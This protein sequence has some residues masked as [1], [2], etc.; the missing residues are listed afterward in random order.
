MLKSPFLSSHQFIKVFFVGILVVFVL[1]A[2][3]FLRPT[4]QYRVGN[5]FFGEFP[6][7]YNVRLAQYFF[8]YAAYPVFGE[9]SIFAHHQLSRTYFIQGK[10]EI[11]AHEAL[12]EIELFPEN[13][14]TYYILGLTY[15]YL[16]REEE[17][18]EAFSEFIKEYPESWAARNDKAWLQFRIADVEGALATLEPVSTLQN[19]WVQNTYGTIL[20]NLNQNIEARKAFLIADKIVSSMSEEEWGKAYPGNDPRVYK[21]GLSAMKNSIKENLQLLDSVEENTF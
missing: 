4:V 19:P 21:I 17:A 20:L 13:K 5:I 11:S 18:I 7:L 9:S 1:F 15:G 14:R 6:A 3:F 10:L 16:N 12:M 8:T 2:L